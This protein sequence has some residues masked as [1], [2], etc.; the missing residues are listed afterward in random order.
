MVTFHGLANRIL[1]E[2]FTELGYDEPPQVLG[3]AEQFA[4]VRELLANEDPADWPAY[5][6]LLQLRGFVDEVRQFLVR[7][8]EEMRTPED[9][10]EA[11]ERRGLTGWQ[12]LARFLGEYQDVL[13]DL[14]VV[15]FGAL[16]PARGEGGRRGSPALRPPA[17]RRPT[18]TPRSRRRPS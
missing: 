2:R 16:A 7:A 14:D 18:R 8:Q 9:I 11:A 4:K 3:A 15:D 6:S 10:A 5:G 13:D 17:R 1:R 12:E